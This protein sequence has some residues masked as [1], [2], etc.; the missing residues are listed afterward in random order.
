MSRGAIPLSPSARTAGGT[1][2]SRR[3]SSTAATIASATCSAGIVFSSRRQ[4]GSLSRWWECRSL[5]TS[6]G[7]DGRHRDSGP[8]QL[9]A[10]RLGEAAV[11]G[12]GRAVDGAPGERAQAGARRDDDDVPARAVAHVA[13]RGADRVD[14]A[15]HVDPHHLLGVLDRL[16]EEGPVVGE[17]GVGDEQLDAARLLDEALDGCRDRVAVGDVGRQD[18]RIAGQLGGERGQRR[19]RRARRARRVR[20]GRRAPPRSRARSPSKPR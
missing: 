19:P 9:V 2:T 5:S 17:P 11:G 13:E 8:R 10:Q 18:D 6:P 1:K 4:S 12:L 15:E 14:R 20:R 7:I 3:S 16:V